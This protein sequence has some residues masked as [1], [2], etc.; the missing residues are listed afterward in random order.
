MNTSGSARVRSILLYTV[1]ITHAGIIAFPCLWILVSAFKNARELATS[2]WG[3]PPVWRFENFVQA[4]TTSRIPAYFLNTAFVILIVLVVGV[5]SASGIAFVLSRF[6][7]AGRMPLYYFFIAGLMIPLHAVVIPIYDLA[8]RLGSLNSLVFLGLVY[9]AF[10]LPLSVLILTSFMSEI[11]REIEESATVDGCSTW[12]LYWRVAMPLTR[13]GLISVVILTSLYAWNE[14]LLALVLI[15]KPDR[16]TI[17][18]GMRTFFAE[19]YVEPTLM[20][21]GCILALIPIMLL[22]TVLQERV[23]K[24]MTVGAL[25]G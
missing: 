13:D 17:S 24:G 2:P 5:G 23:I 9:A 4:W 22:Y 20:L 21:A 3:L 7:F 15:S 14:L 25:R 8:I 12:G 10:Y 6:R 18:V 1:L 11:P 19:N 16:K